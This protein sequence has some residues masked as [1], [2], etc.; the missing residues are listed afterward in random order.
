MKK[1][2]KLIY[3]VELAL[4]F[5]TLIICGLINVIAIKYRI[6]IAITFLLVLLIASYLIFG[7]KKD[8]SYNKNSSIRIVVAK[9]M[10]FGIIA[11]LLGIVLGYNKGYAYSAQSFIYGIVPI[12][13][14]TI[15]TEMLRFILL[16][17]TFGH[18]KTII[19]FTILIIIFNV[20]TKIGTIDSSFKLFMFIV[21][22][23]LPIIAIELLCSYLVMKVGPVSGIIL[24]LTIGLYPYILPIVPNLGDYIK[25]VIDIILVYSTYTTINKGLLEYEK[26]DKY[27]DKFNNRIFTYPIMVVLI[28]LVILV[29]GIFKYQLISIATDSM[30]PI[31]YRGDALL[32]EKCN[33]DNIEVGDI[34]VFKNSNAIVTHRVI[35]KEVVNNDI[36]LT[37]KGDNNKA[38][39]DIISTSS[40]VIGKAHFAIKYIGFPTIWLNEFFHRL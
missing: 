17:N 9:L 37:T 26:N 28:G 23:V 19:I 36:K 21:S 3:L 10:F 33:I 39:D 15:I 30:N 12:V 4:F 2:I 40:N 14:I 18:K 20:A 16:K 13:I 7:L 25:T 11:Y 6:F 1:N 24:K 32:I 35:K 27:I 8:N 31:F 34:L 22:T 38:K 29:S 5:L